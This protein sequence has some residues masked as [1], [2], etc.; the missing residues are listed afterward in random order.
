MGKGPS[1]NLKED[2]KGK[3]RKWYHAEKK[4]LKYHVD[5]EMIPLSSSNIGFV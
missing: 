5:T 4:G 1:P 3:K 2:P